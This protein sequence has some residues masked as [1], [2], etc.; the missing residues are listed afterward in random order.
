MIIRTSHGKYACSALALLAV[1]CGADTALG[2]TE[3]GASGSAEAPPSA[4]D[5]SATSSTEQ[6]QVPLTESF[7]SRREWRFEKRRSALLD[8]EF[9]FNLRSAFFDRVKFDGSETQAFTIGG[10]VGLKTGYFFDHLA[11]G[12]TGYT[13]QPLSAPDD[14][15]GTLLLKPGGQG[16]TVLG[17]AYADI[18]IIEGLN[19]YVGRKEYE[20]PFI[21]G[22]DT[23]MTPKTFEA[24][25]LQGRIELEKDTTDPGKSVVDPGKGS[26]DPSKGVVEQK[27]GGAV[28]KF[29]LGYFDRIKEWNADRFVSMGEDAGAGV[30]RGVYTAGALFEKGN[31]S[32]GAI[33]YYSPDIINIGYAEAKLKLPITADW[34]PKLAAQFVDQR[35]VGDNLLQ[36]DSFSGQQFGIKADL[37]FK[38]ALLTVGYTYTNEGTNMQNPWSSYPGYTSVQVQDFN[39][40]GEGAFLV[41]A[42]YEFTKVKGLSTYALAVFGTKP[43]DIGQY[44]QNEYD[45]SVKWEPP[46]GVLKGLSLRLRY[47]L[48]QQDG[49][50]D[51]QDLKDFRVILNYGGTF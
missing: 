5:Y 12:V 46:E 17:E 10:W 3:A 51:V 31:F 1:L 8:T 39:R 6:G 32:I 38:K 20:T 27:T 28:L 41:R 22:D 30:H 45:F 7:E 15:D 37:P 19:L 43:D 48:I 49:G 42:S 23:R 29:G 44:R 26:M 18:R 35:S 21:N 33:D 11:F 34:E 40:A 25:V 13:S 4:F 36:G 14:K 24:I 47:A 9:K 16:Y 50:G 2:Q